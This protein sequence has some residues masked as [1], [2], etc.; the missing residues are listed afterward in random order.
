MSVSIWMLA[1]AITVDKLYNLNMTV[2]ITLPTAINRLRLTDSRP[3]PVQHTIN[4]RSYGSQNSSLIERYNASIH[5]VYALLCTQY[6][7]YSMN[8][9]FFFIHFMLRCCI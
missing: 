3:K 4:D 8:M 7:P 2:L 9:Y 5:T 1:D 6:I